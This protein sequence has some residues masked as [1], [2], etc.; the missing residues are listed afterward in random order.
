MPHCADQLDP[1]NNKKPGA[2]CCPEVLSRIYWVKLLR[3]RRIFSASEEVKARIRE[4]N[5]SPEEP[6]GNWLLFVLWCII[7][8]VEQ[9]SNVRRLH[10]PTYLLHDNNSANKTHPVWRKFS[11]KPLGR[12]YF[13]LKKK[14]SAVVFVLVKKGS[15]K[16]RWKCRKVKINPV[17]SVFFFQVY[18]RAFVRVFLVSN[19]PLRF[20]TGSR[21]SR[22]VSFVQNAGKL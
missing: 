20:P 2:L 13:I 11:G 4:I 16:V 3:E 15:P 14:L 12:F 7:S 21:F 1:L 9:S 19:I 6:G 5:S 8:K 17:T 18:A 22:L 10:D